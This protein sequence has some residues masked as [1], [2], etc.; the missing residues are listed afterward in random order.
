MDEKEKK[1][2][3]KKKDS[4][5][6]AISV[7]IA[8][9]TAVAATVALL[10]Y[11]GRHSEFELLGE[12]EL[13]LEYGD[14]YED[15]GLEIRSVG[16]LFPEPWSVEIA[17]AVN[18][19][20]TRRLGE[21]TLEYV[22]ADRG[23]EK[24]F[25]RSLRVVDTRAP[26]IELTPLSATGAMNWMTG[27]TEPGYR[28]TDAVDG[29][30]SDQVVVT[31]L[32]DRLVYTVEDASGNRARVERE[33]PDS[34]D[35]PVIELIGGSEYSFASCMSWEDPGFTI[36]GGGG[37]LSGSVVVEGSVTPYHSGEYELSYTLTNAEGESVTAVR[38]VTVEPVQQSDSVYPDRKTIYLTFDD[39]PGPY[40]DRLLD[41]LAR[42][43]VKATF[44]V[45]NCD[46]DYRDC[47]GRAYREGH[48][49]GVHSYTHDYYRIYA[50]EE[51]Y[52]DDFNA[53]QSIIYDETGSYASIFRFPGG[54]SNTVSRFNPGI[55]SRLAQDMTDM[56]YSYFDW[57]I[58]SGDAGETTDTEDVF[59][60]VTSGCTFRYN[61]VLQH[62]IKGFSVA[63]VERIINWGLNNGYQFL[64]LEPG[65]FNAH[66]PIAN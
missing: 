43:N 31:R 38:H 37:D 53:M 41:I 50:S 30:L 5:V 11:D 60:N 18:E 2:K 49:I 21:Q 27:Y 40:T 64:P 3:H 9:L 25:T 58:S 66:H 44:F 52:F 24:R 36:S 32:P 16:R 28:A 59:D 22:V 17:H 62:D 20:D 57:N 26:V 13:T 46:S 19:P 14:S 33:L 1:K 7:M 12:P 42:Y 56:G 48:T 29:D 55:M 10:I 39:G 54:S 23:V 34:F 51:A 65:S 47:I 4:G 63:A 45:T 35:P 61:V 15:P 6:L 8:F